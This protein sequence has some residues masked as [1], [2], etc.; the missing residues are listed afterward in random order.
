MRI[1]SRITQKTS[2]RI[3]LKCC[4]SLEEFFREFL[5]L[6]GNEFPIKP[7]SNKKRDSYYINSCSFRFILPV[8][9]FQS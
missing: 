8:P 5:L 1:F 9:S 6:Y 2:I 4:F 7:N 3:N